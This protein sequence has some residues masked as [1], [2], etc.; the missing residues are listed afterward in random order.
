MQT[1]TPKEILQRSLRDFDR[2]EAL[3]E[4][5]K[6]EPDKAARDR[7]IERAKELMQAGRSL[8]ALADEKIAS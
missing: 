8:R 2:A 5:A 7:L 4:A 6:N 1:V 3:L